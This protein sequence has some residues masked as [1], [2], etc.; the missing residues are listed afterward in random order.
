MI[1]PTFK[2]VDIADLSIG[3][4]S[5]RILQ[6]S[7]NEKETL[8][9]FFLDESMISLMLSIGENGFS[10]IEPLIVTSVNN[11]EYEVIDGNRRLLASKI[12]NNP[13]LIDVQQSTIREIISGCKII[14]KEVPCLVFENKKDVFI[15][16]GFLHITGLKTWNML[17]K[18]HFLHECYQNKSDE[19]SFDEK[20]REI[21]KSIG[22]RKGYV[23]QSLL[24]FQV[25]KAIEDNLFF[26]I[27]SLNGKTFRFNIILESLKQENI[28]KFLGINVSYFTSDLNLI[29]LQKWTI[30]LFEKN[31]QGRTRIQENNISDL[32]IILSNESAIELFESGHSLETAKSVIGKSDNSFFES[33][34]KYA[35]IL[36]DF[37][38]YS[39]DK[40]PDKRNFE[41]DL[42]RISTL[43]NRILKKISN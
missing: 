21:A 18:A 42:K 17:K 40:I 24:G 16:L 26:K 9:H 39:V 15:H 4:S 22:T 14:P 8:T 5:P 12:L 32:D 41:I 13:N 23:K 25:Y 19:L 27:E 35:Y 38:L 20:I 3:F 31:L 1:Q 37:D 30:W 29:N 36:D 6:D 10:P 43:T 11:L 34:K 2:L 33:V 7:Q 28:C